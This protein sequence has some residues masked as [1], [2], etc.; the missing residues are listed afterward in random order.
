VFE[1]DG[2]QIVYVRKG[3]SWEERPI[4]PLKR[5]E[6]V[7]VLAGGVQAGETI[8]VADPNEKPGDKKKSSKGGNSNPVGALPGG[9]RS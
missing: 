3:N 7:T 2:K 9:G 4:K 8:A 1:K 5:T 6:N